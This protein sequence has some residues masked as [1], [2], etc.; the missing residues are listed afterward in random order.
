MQVAGLGIETPALRQ[1]ATPDSD[2]RPRVVGLAAARVAAAW[3]GT[4]NA[5]ASD[6]YRPAMAAAAQRDELPYVPGRLTP[7][8]T[9]VGYLLELQIP[10]S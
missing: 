6:A 4:L 3:V 8:P 9:P 1:R 7:R 10:L 5:A 2:D